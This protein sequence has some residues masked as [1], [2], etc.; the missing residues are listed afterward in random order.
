MYN[1][2]NYKSL[3]VVLIFS[4]WVLFVLKISAQ[5]LLA[6]LIIQITMDISILLLL[7]LIVVILN[8]ISQKEKEDK[9]YKQ[10]KQKSDKRK[11][12]EK[13]LKRSGFDSEDLKDYLQ[14]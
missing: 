4:S 6:A 13:D 12:L 5:D 8:Y 7:T 10:R 11:K 1:L 9:G 14:E 3:M 2:K